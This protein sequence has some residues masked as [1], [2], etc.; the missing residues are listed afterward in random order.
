MTRTNISSIRCIL[1]WLST[2]YSVL[3]LSFVIKCQRNRIRSI[4]QAFLF[5]H[6][7]LLRSA[8]EKPRHTEGPN[9]HVA[10]WWYQSYFSVIKF[11]R[12]MWHKRGPEVRS[13]RMN[14]NISS[15]YTMSISM[16]T[17]Y[18]IKLIWNRDLDNIYTYPW[19]QK[20]TFS[21]YTHPRNLSPDTLPL[22]CHEY[23]WPHIENQCI[24]GVLTSCNPTCQSKV[25]KQD[26]KSRDEDSITSPVVIS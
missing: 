10:L 19:H 11:F 5:L 4:D 17:F 16:Y 26:F 2:N 12:G 25:Q 13:K 7:C 6:G 1:Q 24:V 9:T 18:I 15:H 22:S 21:D 3:F 20:F 23:A 14:K 8:S